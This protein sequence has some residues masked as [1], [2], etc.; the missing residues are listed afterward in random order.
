ME[1][2]GPAPRAP[3]THPTLLLAGDGDPLKLPFQHIT[4]PQAPVTLPLTLFLVEPAGGAFK[5][6][7][8]SRQKGR[9]QLRIP[10]APLPSSL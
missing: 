4:L 2:Q 10:C 8:W 1:I 6:G 5:G 9:L 3:H 7:V